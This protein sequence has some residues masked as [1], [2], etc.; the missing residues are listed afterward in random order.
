MT[1]PCALSHLSL[2]AHHSAASA[3][4]R[5][6]GGLLFARDFLNSDKFIM[7]TLSPAN[8]LPCAG[9]VGTS[10]RADPPTPGLPAQ[11]GRRLERF[12]PF[13]SCCQSM[14]AVW[15]A[16]ASLST[17]HRGPEAAWCP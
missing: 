11:S 15:H 8:R 9:S 16:G 10:C 14:D 2:P 6:A 1:M 5:S 17:C 4:A 13:L 7:G 12:E 3:G